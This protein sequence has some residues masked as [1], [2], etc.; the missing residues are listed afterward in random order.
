MASEI[1]NELLRGQDSA[2]E[3]PERPAW[4]LL[5]DSAHAHPERMALV[6][7]DRS[8]TYGQLNAEAN[9]VGRALVEH[10]AAPETMVAVMADRDSWAYVMREGALKAG[11]AFMPIDPEYP[12]ERVRYILEDS[13]ARMVLTTSAVLSRRAELFSAL[14][15]LDLDV[16]EAREAVFSHDVDDLDVEVA[17][18]S[19]A[20]VIYTSGSTGRPKGV[21]IENR[22]LVNLVYDSDRNMEVMSYTRHGS[23]S[24]A[25][26]ALTFDV[27][28]EEEFIPLSNGM[29]VVMATADDIM[30]PEAMAQLIRDNHVDVLTCTPSYLSNMI[31]IDTFAAVVGELSSVV[32][33]AEAF[34][35]DL[36]DRLRALNAHLHVTNSYGPTECTCA[37]TAL[38]VVDSSDV[39]IGGPLANYYVATVDD[40][41]RLLPAG[42]PGEL[43]IMG[44]GVGR[45]YIGRD[46]LNARNFV[47]LC[48]MPAYRSGDLA[49]VRANGEVEYRGRIDDQVKLRGL[50]VELGEVE[51]VI[52]SFE[53]VRSA[54]VV[55]VKDAQEY[56]AA[57]YVADDDVDT[58]ALRA[59]ARRYLASYMVPQ[60][61]TRLEELPLTANGKVD[62]AALPEPS[63]DDVEIEPAEGEV[64]EKILGLAREIL[65]TER[66]GATTDLVEAGLSSLGAIRL[67]SALR[68]EFGA[69]VKTSELASAPT[70]RDLAR[71][72]DAAADAVDYALREDY[73]LSQTQQGI[74]F[75]CV[76]HPGSTSYNLPM[77][78][79]LD[80][81]VDL[82]RLA[83]AVRTMAEAHPYLNMRV[84]TDDEGLLRA[85]RRDDLK[86]DVAIVDCDELPGVDELVRPFDLESDEML[87]RAAI[88]RT[89]EAS[90][91]YLDAHHIVSDGASIDLMIADIERVFGGEALERETY[92]GFEFALDEEAARASS[93]LAE[94]HDFYDAHFRGCGGET[95]PPKDGD[96]AAGH[97]AFERTWGEADGAAVRAFCAEHG[98]THNAFFTAAFAYALQAFCG[99]EQPIFSAIYNGRSDPRL[100]GCVSMLVKTLPV[101]P[102]SEPDDYVVSLVERCKS[103]LLSAMAN[104]VFSFAEVRRAYGIQ[105]DVMFAFQGEYERSVTLGGAEA[106]QVMLPLSRARAALGVDLMLDGDRIVF[107]TEVDPSAYSASTVSRLVRL[108]DQVVSE[109]LVRDRLRDVHLVSADDEKSLRSL[110]DSDV[111]VAYRPAYRLLQDQADANPDRTAVIGRDATL[112]FGELNARANAVGRT[113]AAHGAGKDTMV[114]VLADRTTWAY[115]MREGALK[116]GA[117]F[118][119]IDPEYPEER[120]RYILED[121]GARIVLTVAG[122][123]ERRAELFSAL[124][125]LELDVID[126][127]EAVDDFDGSDLDVEVAPHDLAYV[128]Y[129]S[130]S[131]GRPKGVMIE[132]HNL[133]NLVDD[134]GKNAE[135]AGFVHH[136][137]VS[138]AIAALTFDVSVE[139]EFIPLANG[140]TVVLA[141][142]DDIM[143][144]AAIAGL[145]RDNDV[146]MICCTPSYLSNL[147]ELKT[148]AS[149]VPQ[150]RSVLVGAEAFPPEL[151]SRLR[152]LNPDVVVTNSY[153]PTECT[154]A[155]TALEIAGATDV[156]IG[157]PLANYHAATVDDL[158]RLLPLGAVGELAILGEGVGRGYIGRDDL[159]ARSF[160][161]LLGMR[162]YRSGDLVRI[163]E[164]GQVEYRG[165]IDDQV[166]LRGL[167]VELGEIESVI[168][169]YPGVRSSVVV[170]AH[171]QSD[172]LAA[173][174]TADEVVDHETLKAHMGA[175]LTAYM[176]PQAIMQL[177]ELPLTANGKVDKRALPEVEA[178][179]RTIVGPKTESQAELLEIVR[180]I[181]DTDQVGITTDLFE[182]GLSSLGCIRLCS[183]VD[184]RMGK[185]LKVADVSRLR[186]VEAIDATLSTTPAEAAFELLDEYPLSQTQ[187]GIFFECMMHPDTTI[188]NIPELYR[189]DDSLDLERLRDALTQALLAHPYLFATIGRNGRGEA[190]AR[191]NEPA[192][193]EIPIGREVPSADELVR[194]FDLEGGERLFRVAL[195]DAPDGKFLFLDTHHIVSDGESI[196]VL[197]TDLGRAYAGEA[198]EPEAFTGFEFALAEQRERAGERLQAAHDFYE[199]ALA[200]CGGDTLPTHDGEGQGQGIAFARLAEKSLASEVRAFCQERNLSANAFYTL[201]FGLALRSF[202][203]A[204]EATFATIYNGRSDSRIARSVSMFVKTL[205]VRVTAP[206][207][208]A[209]A[210]AVSH[211]L[212]MAVINMRSVKTAEEIA[213]MER[214]AEVGY[215]M[216][217]TAMRLIKP[218]VT[219]KYIGGQVDGI[220]LSYGAK[221]SF[222]TIF[223]QHGEIMHGNP[224]MAP[225][226]AGRLAL[227]DCGAETM[228][229]YCSDNTRTMPVNGKYDQRQLDIYRI[230][231]EC[232]DLALDISK[233]GMK[234]MDVH[235]A[236]CRRMTERLKELGLMKGDVDEAVAAGAHAMFL[237]HGLGHMMGMDVHDME[238]L[239]Q[240]YVGFDEETRPNL[241]Q[242]GTNCLR[243]GR[244]LQEG[245]VVTD[246]PGIYFIPALIDDWR[247]SGHCAEFLNFDKLETYKD[248]GGIRIEDDILI[249][250]DG[251]RFLGEKRIPYH[252]KD[253]EDFM[254]S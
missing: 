174:F 232:H 117:A 85:C 102:A 230:V 129:T 164:D 191:R 32:V 30:D 68:D 223:S 248:F 54:V 167:R 46:D 33:G 205:P 96:P 108:I 10:G 24:L 13:G 208:L 110:H 187:Q 168:N 153:G 190:V 220:A 231:E 186:C 137:S 65:R 29:T 160:F 185:V 170:V 31:E 183:L 156:T 228:E 74:Y 9:A 44:A 159:N 37:S 100:E 214:A 79:R 91:L 134:N 120:V 139:E 43:V 89:P 66:L 152:Q 127:G 195:F 179:A 136:G 197:L 172:Y 93:R 224:S 119:P 28:V 240:I 243:M 180:D 222:A 21:M 101:T 150:L 188:Y 227:C 98:L 62:K 114:A 144:P 5:Q 215:L 149:V 25:M 57:Y 83:A 201:A 162:A 123:L 112:T 178:A 106:S 81:S 155:A 229:F 251:C 64:E 206:D 247:A 3:V 242:F 122:V 253:V 131:T 163:R 218:G 252:P 17:P 78:Y 38:E 151:F 50:R 193:V 51:R 26:A 92:T 88:Y 45:G 42:E 105:A 169:A 73:P 19:L 217:T 111:P 204:E 11:A 196:D 16:V 71:L 246:E 113:L 226:E 35:A 69:A 126:A 161:E 173:Y 52:E 133:V 199:R 1:E 154:C 48:G 237:P 249:T 18:E 203:F 15:D 27:S 14:S 194:P 138:L 171:G 67:C 75:E 233:P 241:E 72:V 60:S 53:S 141:T 63:L 4:R 177:D 166:K 20:Y 210:E 70:V 143:D 12:E 107:E 87:C 157:T 200:G 211:D 209:P 175:Y 22:N 47:E 130:G 80:A 125:D 158:G 99:A 198:V 192:P 55:V 23:V 76:N 182:A 104:D 147:I 94:A 77:L 140:N 97:M 61:L 40:Q 118:M 132:N 103:Y 145:I 176:V 219:E 39:T 234:Y 254:A 56:L 213:E 212:R 238:G 86:L 34:P 7:R 148:F 245:F 121:S 221:N 128:I 115:V 6:A 41:G 58:D 216:H 244:R 142:N 236:V 124:A 59:H 90:Y 250:A 84:R 135:V 49:R 202:C 207:N 36:F 116:A 239:G 2:C 109:F 95:L 225:L 165:R 181:V 235:M 8:L 82:E 146:T 189:I 184:S